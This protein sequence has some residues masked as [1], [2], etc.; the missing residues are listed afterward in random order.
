[1][2]LFITGFVQVF[3][4]AV[5]TYFLANSLFVGVFGTSFCISW[6]WSHNVKKVAFG[7][8][9]D[10]SLYSLGASVGSVLGLFCSK[11]IASYL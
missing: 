11:F 8:T 5:N 4:V 1:M 7:S 9:L 10:R 2:K 6:V 3:F